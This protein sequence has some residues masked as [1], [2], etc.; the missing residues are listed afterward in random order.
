MD[1]GT[2]EQYFW[3]FYKSYMADHGPSRLDCAFRFVNEHGYKAIFP[4]ED[5]FEHIP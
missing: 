1:L 2:H 4:E 5:I 3:P